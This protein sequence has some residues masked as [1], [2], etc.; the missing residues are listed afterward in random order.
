MA[1]RG[2]RLKVI[3]RL[4]TPLPGLTRKSAERRPYPP[5]VHGAGAGRRKSD[6]RRRLEEKQKVRLHYGVSESQ[7]RRYFARTAR[8]TGATGA[9][10]LALLIAG[11]L[12]RPIT[13]LT[14][15]VESIGR[16]GIAAIPVDATGETAGEASR[17]PEE[18]AA[19]SSIV[20]P[21]PGGQGARPDGNGGFSRP[22]GRL[23]S[24]RTR[25]TLNG[26]LT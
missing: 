3:R 24:F 14:K 21:G 23:T 11:S 10:A 5:G 1:R 20:R 16:G 25:S 26:I 13:Q 2:P 19:P 6:H 4:G 22:G 17:P 9:A 18:R 7:L 12:T 15:A 8:Q